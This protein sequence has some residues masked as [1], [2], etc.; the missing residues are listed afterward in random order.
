MFWTLG[1]PKS[2]D[3]QPAALF[4]ALLAFFACKQNWFRTGFCTPNNPKTVGVRMLGELS[5]RESTSR[6]SSCHFFGQLLKSLL[7]FYHVQSG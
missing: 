5:P 3:N 6:V 4:I 7:S 1:Y 2:C